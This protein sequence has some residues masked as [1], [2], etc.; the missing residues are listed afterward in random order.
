LRISETDREVLVNIPDKQ[1]DRLRS[2]GLYVSDGYPTNHSMAGG[3]IVGKPK[4]TP[5]NCIP[6]S[7]Y[8]FAPAVH[9]EPL[10]FDAPTVTLFET[11]NVWGVEAVDYVPGPGPADFVDEWNSIDEAV[12]DILDF[13]TGNPSRMQAK[14][15]ARKRILGSDSQRADST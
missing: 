11:E 9:E 3:V 10:K 5:G 14:A 8:N 1:L 4:S 15:A 13:Y 12:S 2:A 6:G 7:D